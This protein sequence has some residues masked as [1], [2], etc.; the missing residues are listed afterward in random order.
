MNELFGFDDYR[1]VAWM[2]NGLMTRVENLTRSVNTRI[3][4]AG[5]VALMAVSLAAT[6][7]ISVAHTSVLPGHVPS[8]RPGPVE[9]H[10][11]SMQAVVDRLGKQIDH[12]IENFEHAFSVE[13]DAD[14]LALAELAVSSNNDSAQ[15]PKQVWVERLSI[16]M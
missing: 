7:V 14:L 8:V 12:R 3:K 9:V 11:A 4:S 10:E 13:V 6:P 16:G 5:S 2:S 1:V 15:L